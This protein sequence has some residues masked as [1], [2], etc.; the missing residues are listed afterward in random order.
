M[1]SGIGPAEHLKSHGIAPIVDHPGVGQRLV[2]HPVIDLF[3][4][5]K[6]NT[7][8]KWIKPSSLNDTLKV[9]GAIFQYRVLGTGGPLAMNVCPAIFLLNESAA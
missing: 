4:K 2:D 5:D 9:F 7:S 6:L 3:F 1:L 8:P